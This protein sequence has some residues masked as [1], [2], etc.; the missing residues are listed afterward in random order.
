MIFYEFVV[1]LGFSRFFLIWLFFFKVLRLY[2]TL[3]IMKDL[4]W[5]FLTYK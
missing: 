4:I 2:A 1:I 3:G 5:L